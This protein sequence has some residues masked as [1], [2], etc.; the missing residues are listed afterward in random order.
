MQILN[1]GRLAT[2]LGLSGLAVLGANVAQAEETT[3]S[4][5]TETLTK[6]DQLA[7]SGQY[8]DEFVSFSG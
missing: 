3:V 2:T 4:E 7:L 1:R 8:S 6:K 5:G